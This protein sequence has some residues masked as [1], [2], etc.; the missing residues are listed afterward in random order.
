MTATGSLAPLRYRPFR[1]LVTGRVLTALGNG[2]APIAL[3]FAVLD[4]TGSVADVGL[5]VGARSLAN[6]VFMLFGGV[7]ADRLPRHL[8]LVG[9]SLLAAGTQGAV[10]AL[11]LTGTATIPLLMSL[12]A[13]NGVVAAFAFPATA[14]LVPQTVP[15]TVRR[16][17]NAVNRL[18]SN[19][20]M[21]IGA[22]LGG[23]LVAAVGPGWGLAADALTFL[24]SGLAFAR[25]RVPELRQRGTAGPGVLTELREGWR[26]F[27]GRTWV[28]VVVLAFMLINAALAGAHQV[29]GPAVADAT[30]GR[31]GWGLVLATE[32][33]GMVVG[34][35]I[36][37][38]LRVRRLLLLGVVCCF[39]EVPLV[40]A[41]A[42][43]A[44]LAGTL[45]LPV[46]VLSALVAGMAIEQFGVAWDTSLQDQIPADRLARVYSYDMLGSILAMPVGQVVAGPVALAVG[47]RST[48]LGAAGIV[49]LAT[50]GMLA[51]RDVRRMEH[52]PASAAE[53][54]PAAR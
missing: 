20:A 21:I 1:N 17:A 27:A 44:D 50:L 12:G 36:A 49:L 47:T 15:E 16:A 37:L 9:S 11:V 52:R 34:G 48:L 54:A 28:W 3:A 6:V 51:S 45:R 41:L 10:A 46:L 19:A 40:V 24:L 22:A 43:T 13:V 32:T 30:I 5:V 8:V 29:L 53:P 39:A 23:V 38:R 26:E 14:A 18:A 2:V 35:L 25:V 7:L 33:T 4:L 42:L 31:S